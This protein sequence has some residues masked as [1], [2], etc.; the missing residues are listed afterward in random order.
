MASD[1]IVPE[2]GQGIPGV[3]CSLG[4]FEKQGCLRTTAVEHDLKR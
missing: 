4:D 2:F 1:S 3:P